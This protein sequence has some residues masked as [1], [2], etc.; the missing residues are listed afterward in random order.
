MVGIEHSLVTLNNF[1]FTSP[2][3]TRHIKSHPPIKQKMYIKT[4]E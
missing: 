1:T 2:S 3:V 4:D